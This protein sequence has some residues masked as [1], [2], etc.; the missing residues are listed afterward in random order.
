MS[1][2][3]I[4]IDIEDVAVQTGLSVQI[5]HLCV[6]IGI[7]SPTKGYTEKDLAE[8]R[9]VRRLIHDLALEPTAVEVL[10]RMRRRMHALQTEVQQLRTELRTS[11]QRALRGTW[12]EAEWNELS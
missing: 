1:T 9:C 10:L 12:V 2:A 11:R 4:L 5:I 3:Y 8:L 7:V 6:D